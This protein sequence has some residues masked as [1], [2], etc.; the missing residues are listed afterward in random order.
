MT[1]TTWTIALAAVLLLAACGQQVRLPAPEALPAGDA[2][3]TA[4]NA[5]E[6][7]FSEYVEGSS[8][9][10][11]LEIY[12]GTDAAIDLG[13]GGYNIQMFF[14]GSATAGLTINLVGTVAAGDV[15][16]LAQA[17]ANATI[18]AQADQTNGAGWFNGDDAVAL[19]KGSALLDVIGQIGFDP[20]TEWGS[21]LASTA[22]NTLRRL[23]SVCAGDPDGSDAFDPSVTWVGFATDTFDGLGAHAVDCSTVVAAPK[24]NE[25]VANHAGADTHEF[26]EIFGAPDTDYGAYTLLQIEGDAGPAAG[27][28]DAA[29]PVGTTDAAGF[30]ST[31]FL[32]NVLENG[33]LT[34]LLVEGFTGSVGTDLD[35]NDDG[36]LDATPWTAVADGVA[37]SDGGTGDLT[38]AAT[39]LGAD[40]D[41]GTFAPGGA[42]RIPDGGPT[43]VRND[44]DGA[45][46]PGFVGTPDAGEALNTP[47]A[48][49]APVEVVV[50]PCTDAFTP[51]SAIQ[52]SGETSPLVGQTVTTLG[53]VVGDYEGPAPALRGFYLQDPVGDGDAATSEGIFVFNGNLDLV[54]VG[55]LVAVSGTAAEFQGQTQISASGVVACGTGAV[56][57]VDVALPVPDATYLE[58][59]EGMLVRFPQTLVVTETFQ[60]GRFGQV[61]MS[62]E[63]R[64][65]Q[66][67][68]VVAPGAAANA[69]QAANA[70]NRIIVDDALNAQN[71]LVLFGR[72]GQPLSA[73][74]TLRG[75][76]TATS[77]VG[78][79]TYT[80]AGNS[81]S[82]NAYR[83]RT[84]HALG[85]GEP[86]FQPTNPRPTTAPD[87]GGSLRVGALN[88][89]NYF[90]TFGGGACTNGIAG[91][92]TDCR[93]AE[94]ALEFERQAVKTV[95]TILGMDVDVLGII[96]IE[97]DGY[98]PDSAI[99]DLVDRLNAAAGAGAWAFID[100]DARTGQV[101]ALGHDA[102]KVGFL[103]RPAAVQPVGATAALN[104]V[105][106]VNA[107]D[108][109]ARN[110][111][112]LAQAF[113][114]NGSG[115]VFVAAVNHLKSKGSA[116][117][118]PDAGDGQ[119]NCSAVRTTAAG[120]LV[121]WLATDPTGM[122]DADVIILGD[123]NAYAKEDAVAA[124]EAADF[125][126][127]QGRF[128]G[129]EAYSYV[130]DGQW[131]SLDYALASRSLD[132]QVVGTAAW[133]TNADEPTVLDYNTNFKSPSQIVD[134]FA[135]D[136][137]RA[138][139]HDPLIVG[140]DLDATPTC[141]AARPSVRNLWPV[142]H[143]YQP[144]AIQ[145]VM[146]SAGLPADVVITSVFQ[147]EL[148]DAPGDLDG[149]TSPDAADLGAGSV[150][151]RAERFEGGNGRVYHV[152][153]VA[154]DGLGQSCVGSVQVKVAA[155]QGRNGP[156][157]DDGPLYDSTLP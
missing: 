96:E 58:R 80:W 50:D 46:L 52:G 147:D 97:N 103:Y 22:D 85:G 155:N 76:D 67:T 60:L 99:A 127:L 33:T 130:F 56:A 111:P 26:V 40:F 7:F 61:V 16:V 36:V 83:L 53:V 28:I 146:T 37:V 128:G 71:P 151:L 68:Q 65:L 20:G 144:V 123:L 136:A 152:G 49:N 5:T 143:R 24:I 104:G 23:E 70:L 129:D 122:G 106:F 107:G 154:T 120:L 6:L 66:P 35:T 45:G 19:R 14:N 90:D 25:F 108:P 29:F 117:S 75:G 118:V 10:K 9:N 47:A 94:N 145:G 13:A 157:V 8:N 91:G 89:L 48:P 93:G 125:V 153:F 119:G 4:A 138:S 15:F 63:E 140:I 98:G 100:A 150:L 74:N 72:G 38:Y 69:L 18:L 51:I 1:R 135:P 54:N 30:W 132:A 110:R 109:E 102:I 17:S 112:A 88:V 62:G 139:D 126:N 41:G 131:G 39:V 78:V 149:A 81:A 114:R 137:F 95:A 133:H 55:D 79:L 82:G 12:N 92:S 148:V 57:P 59:Y 42:S 87:V 116:C 11:A 64:L 31:G 3:T 34:L 44:F 113:A 32:A 105:D 156:A 86:D 77:L 43:W 2:L 27:T 21:G 141:S 121:D 142:N 134:L 84:Q 101:D 115:A 124:I 73:A